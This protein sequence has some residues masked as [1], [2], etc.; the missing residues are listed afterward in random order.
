MINYGTG[1]YLKVINGRV[2]T[3]PD[4]ADS[5]D[6]YRVVDAGEADQTLN[7]ILNGS[8]AEAIPSSDG[9]AIPMPRW[10]IT[11]KED[12][13]DAF[14]IADSQS[15]TQLKDAGPRTEIAAIST[16]A[17][18][19]GPEHD[20]IQLWQL[21]ALVA[22][23]LTSVDQTINFARQAMEL[24]LEQWEDKK[25]VYT[26]KKPVATV[27]SINTHDIKTLKDRGCKMKAKEEKAL[28]DGGVRID[29]QGFFQKKGVKDSPYF[30]NLQGQV[31][32]WSDW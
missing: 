16:D 23:S 4:T 14:H 2:V 30:A 8:S 21:V 29:R 19:R 20:S 24:L 12:N 3:I 13:S 15:G 11:P 10:R 31:S 6:S 7:A 25:I 27:A 18:P 9:T 1:K 32:K 17:F 5:H 22:D 28:L 26:P